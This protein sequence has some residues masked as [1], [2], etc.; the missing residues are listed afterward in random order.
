MLEW[1]VPVMCCTALM[2]RMSISFHCTSHHDA[3][4]A[5]E[6]REGGGRGVEGG[7]RVGEGMGKESKKGR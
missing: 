2:I 7:R 6:A 3:S 1:R 4:T 5:R